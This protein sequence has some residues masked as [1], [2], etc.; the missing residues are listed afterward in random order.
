MQRCRWAFKSGWASSNVVGIIYPLIVIGLTELPN[1]KWAKA[2]P[3]HP[4]EAA[5]HKYV[6]LTCLLVMVSWVVW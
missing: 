5:L 4:L 1:S 6:P 3:A 2:H